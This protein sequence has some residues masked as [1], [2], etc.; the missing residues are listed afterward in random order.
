MEI[1][2]LPL[3][4]APPVDVDCLRIEEQPGG[5]FSLTASALCANDENGDSMSI[6]GGPSFASREAAEQAGIAWA[7]SLGAERLI[8]GTGTLSRPLQLNEIDLPL[9][10]AAPE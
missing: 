9:Q 1:I 3:G 7:R 5:E 6:A 8:V 4:E 10:T 2:R